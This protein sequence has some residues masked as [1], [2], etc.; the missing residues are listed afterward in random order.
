MLFG[1]REQI[2]CPGN[3]LKKNLEGKLWSEILFIS[4]CIMY[5][6]ELKMDCT[7]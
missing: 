4:I 3:S 6:L 2:S 5:H 7:P 1:A